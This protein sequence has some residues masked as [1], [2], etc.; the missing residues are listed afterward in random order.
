MAVTSYSHPDAGE[1]RV[2]SLKKVHSLSQFSCWKDCID[3][4]D[5]DK[6]LVVAITKEEGNC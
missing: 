1:E 5:N 2:Y 6:K 4:R 3:S